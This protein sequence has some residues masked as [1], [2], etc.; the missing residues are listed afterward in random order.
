M[1]H[2]V[3]AKFNL[4]LSMTYDVDPMDSK[5]L[6]SVFRACTICSKISTKHR[7]GTYCVL[8]TYDH[9]L[10]HNFLLYVRTFIIVHYFPNPASFPISLKKAD[11]NPGKPVNGG[12]GL[13]LLAAVDADL[14]CCC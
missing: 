14:D 9:V 11:T 13:P 1:R 2:G 6:A 4:P 5:E 12:C 8:S 3:T 10:H 7:T